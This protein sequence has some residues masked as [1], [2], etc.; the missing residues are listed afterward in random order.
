[1]IPESYFVFLHQGCSL[2]DHKSHIEADLDSKITHIFPAATWH[3][4]YYA[5]DNVDDVILDAIR[6]DVFVDMIECNRAPEMVLEIEDFRLI[7]PLGLELQK[8]PGKV[9]QRSENKRQAE[10]LLMSSS[11]HQHRLGCC[12][13]R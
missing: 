13:S 10:E 11:M 6:A 3:G 4:L 7:E 1:M 5:A 8:S 12:P 2:E 9:L